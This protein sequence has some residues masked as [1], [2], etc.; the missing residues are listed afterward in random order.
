MTAARSRRPLQTADG[1][2]SGAFGPVE[3]SLM[4]A[5]SLIWGSSFLWIAIG[6]DSLHPGVI[7]LGR[8][9][10]GG[11]AIWLLPQSRVPVARSAWF[12]LTIIAVTGVAG[13]ALLFAFAEQRVESSV[14]GMINSAT[15]LLVLA[16]SVIMLRRSPGSAQVFGL[17][18][19]FAGGVLL[20]LPNLTGADAQPL[21]VLFVLIA[22]SG[23][24]ISSHLITP[25]AQEYG[26]A[27]IIARSLAIASVMLLP[28]GLLTLDD[29][30]FEWGPVMA[31][32]ILGVLG[33]GFARTLFATLLARA[34]APRA[35]MV[36]YFVPV[37]AI[38]LGVVVRDESVSAVE[39][40]G[41]GVVLVAATMIS[42]AQRPA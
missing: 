35:S 3:W 9:A 25:L 5:T 40:I 32:V 17:F 31:V 10:L 7:A 12:P 39:V 19:G 27:S 41:L 38:V 13:P 24:A 42:R 29:S 14:A 11:V 2:H 6:L 36:S 8:S 34:G 37:V 4:T 33:T 23:Y 21:G 1:S 15:P 28:Y 18:L 22:I 16:V 30:R 26:A 20:A